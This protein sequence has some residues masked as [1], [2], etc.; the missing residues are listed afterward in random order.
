MTWVKLEKGDDWEAVYYALPGERL[1]GG[2]A[3]ASNGVNLYRRTYS[4]R[5]PD[6]H[7]EQCLLKTRSHTERDFGHGYTRD[8][9]TETVWAVVNFHGVELWVEVSE[10]ELCKEEL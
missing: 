4:V 2:C 9:K 5:F 7:I 3:S 1:K 6:G 8:I 10:V